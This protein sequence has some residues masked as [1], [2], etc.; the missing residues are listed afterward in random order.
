[1][2]AFA[3]IDG[4]AGPGSFL[5]GALHTALQSGIFL[6]AALFSGAVLVPIL[7]PWIPGRAFAVKGAVTGAAA[8][9][10]LAVLMPDLGLRGAAWTLFVVAISSFLG[11]NFTGSST[12]T[13]LSGVR[14]EMNMAVPAQIVAV[15]A[16]LVFWIA[17]V[18][19]SSVPGS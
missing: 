7:L 9:G 13:S 16:G 10:L 19:S 18:F 2:L 3:L 8:V 6:S 4:V 15:A 1:M 5:S 14:R 11:M 17:S 12:Y